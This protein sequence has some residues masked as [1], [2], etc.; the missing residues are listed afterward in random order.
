MKEL[1]L[2]LMVMLA[3]IIVALILIL[4]TYHQD[5][6]KLKQS[7]QEFMLY[8]KELKSQT[9]QS[10]IKCNKNTVC[11]FEVLSNHFKKLNVRSIELGLINE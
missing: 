9:D 4:P 7:N 5:A 11:E 3:L 10:L 8:Q 2:E 6:E 1:K